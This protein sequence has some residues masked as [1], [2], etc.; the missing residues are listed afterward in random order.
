MIEIRVDRA[1]HA[2]I[3]GGEAIPANDLADT[4]RMARLIAEIINTHSPAGAAVKQDGGG[5]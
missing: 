4:K 2:V 3:I 5:E 1:K